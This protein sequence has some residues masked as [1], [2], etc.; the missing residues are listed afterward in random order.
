MLLASSNPN[1]LPAEVA[2]V[3][4]ANATKSTPAKPQPARDPAKLVER[5]TKIRE[6]LFWLA[7]VWANTLSPD[8][9]Y[10]ADRFRQLF[11]DL[12]D[13]LRKQ[14]A[15][16]ADR[17]IRGHEALLLSDPMPKPTLP[18]RTQNWIEM[19]GE[20]R[21]TPRPAPKEQPP[22]YVSDGLQGFL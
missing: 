20:V 10:E 16:A 7:A 11:R 9:A 22:G 2:I 3:I 4:E 14:D 1:H 18:L 12:A 6:R 13:E 17:L 5:L 19:A 21:S 15:D 8:V